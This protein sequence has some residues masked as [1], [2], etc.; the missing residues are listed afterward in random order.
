MKRKQHLDGRQLEQQATSNQ[1]PNNI[2]CFRCH[3]IGHKAK[4]CP[5][6]HRRQKTVSVSIT[7]NENQEMQRCYTCSRPGHYSRDCP[8]NNKMPN[9]LYV[10]SSNSVSYNNFNLAKIQSSPQQQSPQIQ[11]MM[12]QQFRF[13]Q[14]EKGFGQQQQQHQMQQMQQM[15]LLPNHLINSGQISVGSLSTMQINESISIA[16]QSAPQPKYINLSSI[17]SSG[18][19]QQRVSNNQEQQQQAHFKNQ[20]QN[21]NPQEQVS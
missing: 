17:N 13:Q 1:Q 10:N 7:S 14:N 15:Y 12:Q 5:E 8:N 6:M 16:Q 2:E 11:H 9:Q 18:N 4:D 19:N 20:R 21:S 3:N